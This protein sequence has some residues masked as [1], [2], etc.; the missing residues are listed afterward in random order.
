MPNFAF[1]DAQNLYL[2]VK[3]QNWN[4][5]YTRFKKYLAEKYK[6]EKA[7]LFIGYLP[8]NADLYRDLQSAG[9]ILIFK[10]A[11]KINNKI[12]KGNVDAE[13]VL[14]AMIQYDQYEKAVIVSGDGDFACLIKYLYKQEKLKMVLVP[15]QQ[16][17]SVLIKKTAKEKIDF[18]SGLKQKLTTKNGSTDKDKTFHRATKS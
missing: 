11:L 15:N 8:E 16:R 9:Y 17:Y 1:I 10:E 3:S 6:V 14:E 18:V 12:I 13:L 2:G 5:D 7:F 4:L